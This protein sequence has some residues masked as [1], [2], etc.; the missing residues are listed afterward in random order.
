[1]DPV[2]MESTPAPVDPQRVREAIAYYQ[3]ASAAFKQGRMK[4]EQKH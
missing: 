1:V 2:T 3:T 4:V